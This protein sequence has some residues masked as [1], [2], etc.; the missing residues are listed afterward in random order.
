MDCKEW[1]RKRLKDGEYHLCDVI[2][3]EAY[4]EGFKKSELKKARKELG[5]RTWHQFDEDGATENW[6]WY[7]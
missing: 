6:F 5:V 2:K 7:L 4:L 3:S 1:L